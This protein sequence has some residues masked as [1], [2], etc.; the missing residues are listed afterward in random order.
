MILRAEQVHRNNEDKKAFVIAC[1][2]ENMSSEDREAWASILPMLVDFTVHL[3]KS[4]V[5]LG[6]R[7]KYGC[8]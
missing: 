2:T 7:K 6:A 8:V 3:M 5:L 4:P 1:V